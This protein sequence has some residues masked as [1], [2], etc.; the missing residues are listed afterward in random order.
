M[1]VEPPTPNMPHLP[2]HPEDVYSDFTH[3]AMAPNHPPHPTPKGIGLGHFMDGRKV[4]NLLGKVAFKS[5][6]IKGR[7][8][9]KITI[10]H[11]IRK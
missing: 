6:G 1:A 4:A 3:R 5:K 2:G 10:P 7:S 8:K 9:T 11:G